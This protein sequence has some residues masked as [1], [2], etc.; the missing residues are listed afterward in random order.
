MKRSA[1]A[2][3]VLAAALLAPSGIVRAQLSPEW[4]RC[5]NSGNRLDVDLQIGGCTAV[6]QGGRETN[7][8]LGIA[9]GNRGL[10]WRRKGDNAKAMADY[11]QAI[12]LKPDSAGSL[13]GRGNIHND[14]KEFDRALA[15]FDVAIRLSPYTAVIYNNRGNS[16][17]GKRDYPRALRDYDQ[18]IK[19]NPQYANAYN[20]RGATYLEMGQHDRAIEDFD[21]ALR[22]EPRHP[23]ALGNRQLALKAKAGR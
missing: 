2:V 16:W 15:D 20:G 11:D 21:A 17:A 13:N 4:Q 19:L 7:E 8:N 22:I 18:A 23:D 1:V 6:I 5:V 12:R 3:A 14:R 9:Y 10:A